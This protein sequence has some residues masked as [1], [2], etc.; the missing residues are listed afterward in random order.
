MIKSFD[1]ARVV[2]IDKNKGRV[3]LFA[4]NGLVS[5]GTYLYDINDLKTGM[6]VLI[7]DVDGTKVI[8]DKVTTG[9]KSSNGMSLVKPVSII[10]FIYTIIGDRHEVPLGA[11]GPLYDFYINWGDG[12]PID[13]VTDHSDFDKYFHIYAIDGIHEISIT[14]I[15]EGFSTMYH[16]RNIVD[17]K[18]WGC[19]S[20][21]RASAH[22]KYCVDLINITA[23]D[24]PNLNETDTL[25]NC[26]SD[27]LNL[28]T[29]SN[30]NNWDVS[31]V[32]N[33]TA[34]F[35]GSSFN[36]DISGWDVSNVEI[37]VEMFRYNPNFNQP[38][39]S[40]NVSKVEEMRSMFSRTNVFNQPL[41]NWNTSKVTDM[42]GMFYLASSFN[43]DISMWNISNV[44][45]MEY[46]FYGSAFSTENYEKLL[47]GWSAQ[48]VQ[49]NVRFHAGS[50]KYHASY[51]SYKQI[52][53]NKGW[54]ITDGGQ[55]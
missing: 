36:S 25:S 5:V 49:S 21:K 42:G 11:F 18:Q 54:Q 26:F 15:I 55:I 27:C 53:V 41:N 9:P 12:S 14:G 34:M 43:Q 29:I 23:T 10:P 24:V 3:T 7:G 44:T 17:I 39:N 22:F 28:L 20:F 47:V 32:T 2:S 45:D 30:I 46:M 6:T 19:F 37:M 1:Q 38:L 13:H 4:K 51:A 33:M 31:S 48:N 8:L 16:N 52:L 40:W 35:F 50:A